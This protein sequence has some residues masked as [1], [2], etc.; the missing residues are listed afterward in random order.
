MTAPL[1]TIY[2][3]GFPP[4]EAPGLRAQ[5]KYVEHGRIY[6]YFSDKATATC[7]GSVVRG[8]TLF[9]RVKLM[10]MFIPSAIIIVTKILALD[11]DAIFSFFNRPSQNPTSPGALPTSSRCGSWSRKVLVYKFAGLQVW[12]VKVRNQ[13]YS[14]T[15]SNFI[16]WVVQFWFQVK[17]VTPGRSLRATYSGLLEKKLS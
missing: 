9:K 16:S 8:Q 5:N 13:C 17:Y 12:F 7:S 2:I 11:Y 10:I 1:R 4:L 14:H 3:T 6:H 15:C